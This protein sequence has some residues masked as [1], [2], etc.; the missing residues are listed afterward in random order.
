MIK[1][2]IVFTYFLLSG[3]IISRV[4]YHFLFKDHKV[5]NELISEIDDATSKNKIYLFGD[6]FVL[7]GGIKK[8]DRIAN[9]LNKNKF[10]LV[11]LARPG[12]TYPN[13]IKSILNIEDSLEQGDI[14]LLGINFRSISFLSKGQINQVLSKIKKNENNSKQL[15]SNKKN[16]RYKF[17]SKLTQF[18]KFNIRNTLLR[19]GI[20][21]PFGTFYSLHKKHYNE[22]LVNEIRIALEYINDL[23]NIKNIRTYIYLMPDFN[24]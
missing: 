14:I 3:E 10:K 9:I 16:T 24:L 13:F 7:G 23:S 15:K 21:L 2:V 19:K 12:H 6:S 1:I 5:N 11:N 4:A 20:M 17:E 8:E 18:L 22:Q